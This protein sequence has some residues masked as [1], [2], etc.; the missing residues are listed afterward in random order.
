MAD[1]DGKRSQRHG[2]KF[3]KQQH[4]PGRQITSG[5]SAESCDTHGVEQSNRLNRRAIQ[6]SG[7]SARGKCRKSTG[8]ISDTHGA[9][10][11]NGYWRAA[12]WIWC[13]DEK[14]R[15]TEPGV[16]PLVDG[17]SARVVRLRGYG[18]AIVAPQAQAF[19]ESYME[20]ENA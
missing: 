16:A 12:D 5:Y 11:T 19:I 8:N 13:R 7:Q 10:P 1:G 20:T 9:G 14:W 3:G 18:N 15:P 4:A 2:Q 17:S 6:K